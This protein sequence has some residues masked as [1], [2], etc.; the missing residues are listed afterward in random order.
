MRKNVRLWLLLISVVGVILAGLIGAELQR[1][2]SHAL[3]T[4]PVTLTLL[5]AGALPLDSVN[6]AARDRRGNTEGVPLV[7]GAWV[8]EDVLVSGLELSLP[9]SVVPRLEGVTVTIGQETYRFSAAELAAA[10]SVS[11]P[12]SVHVAYGSPASLGVERS[13]IPGLRTVINWAGDAAVLV[14]VVTAALWKTA[15]C[16]LFLVLA[17]AVVPFGRP[18]ESDAAGRG[19]SG[20]VLLVCSALALLYGL[21]FFSLIRY[22]DTVNPHGDAWEY[23]AMAVATVQGHGLNRL[24]GIEPYEAYRFR[25]AANDSA[26]YRAQCA[27]WGGRFHSYRTPGYPAFLAGVYEVFGISP[28]RAKQA[29]LAMLILVAAFLPFVGYAYWKSIGFY[30]G[31]IGGLI[32]FD[33][34]YHIAA[35]MYTE[36]LIIFVLFLFVLGFLLWERKK[37]LPRAV[38]LGVLCGVALLVKGDLVFVPLLVLLYLGLQAW[39]KAIPARQAAVFAV[40]CVLTVAPWSVYASRMSGE[41]VVLSTQGNRVLLEG[42]NEEVAIDGNWHPEYAS[43]PQAFYNRKDIRKL[44]VLER[45]FRF[46]LAHPGIIPRMVSAKLTGAFGRFLYLR[47]AIFFVLLRLFAMASTA[48][49]QPAGRVRKAT[50][51]A[52]LRYGGVLVALVAVTAGIPLMFL[53]LAAT[54]LLAGRRHLLRRFVFPVS[55]VVLLVNFLLITVIIFG[56]RRFVSV[57]DSFFTLTAMRFLLSFFV[58]W[59]APRELLLAPPA[60]APVPLYEG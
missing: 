52:L 29:Q 49:P 35:T 25:N 56:D 17:V 9:R 55:F 48:E 38:L 15:L 23:Q 10:W 12:D 7:N 21:V 46:Y 27:W 6:V 11:S 22:E 2:W 20:R 26:D 37:T 58:L 13:R 31:V 33:G 1:D 14:R 60:R 43:D 3:T 53:A 28:A 57:I 47:L 51:G 16:L 5:P 18:T 30:G 44:P 54:L 32:F 40:V 42:N 19:H 39:K 34:W 24:G 4:R 36:V 8:A 50:N 41:L 59:L 45:V